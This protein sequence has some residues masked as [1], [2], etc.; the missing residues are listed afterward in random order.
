MTRDPSRVPRDRAIRR[1]RFPGTRDAAR[2]TG[3]F[4]DREHETP[5]DFEQFLNSLR[6]SADYRAQI[7]HVHHVPAR[8]WGRVRG[9]AEGRTAPIRRIMARPIA[10]SVFRE[11]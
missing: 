11:T 5:V 6:A 7:V 3:A 2:G 4:H 1:H 10:A 8:A 9:A